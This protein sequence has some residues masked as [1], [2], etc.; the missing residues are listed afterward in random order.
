V[1]SSLP[2]IEKELDEEE[3]V[4]RATLI[5]KPQPEPKPIKPKVIPKPKPKPKVEKIVQKTKPKP[6]PNKEVATKTKKPKQTNTVAKKSVQAAPPAEVVAKK[7]KAVTNLAAQFRQMRISTVDMTKVQ[8][9]NV[10]NSDAGTTQRH[11]RTVLGDSTLSKRSSG[12]QAD[13]LSRGRNTVALA[14]HETVQLEGELVGEGGS[15]TSGTGSDYAA[16]SKRLRSDESIRRIFEAGKSRAYIHYQDALNKNTSLAGT[17]MFE[18][19]IEP[20]GHISMIK[21]LNSELNNAALESKILRTIES[22]SFGAQDV[23]PRRLTYKFN[24]L[25]T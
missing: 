15:Y 16:G 20:E 25:P 1:V 18:I 21:I 17:V 13:N 6:K 4:V 5:L 11:S 23:S 2:G 24:F 7:S 12:V 19:V 9:K 10:S 8:R 14:S 3:K 22:L